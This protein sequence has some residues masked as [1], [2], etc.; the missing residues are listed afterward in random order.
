MILG[1]EAFGGELGHE[2]S[3]VMIGISVIKENPRRSKKSAVCNPKEGPQQYLA[4]L[5]PDLRPPASRTI[6]NK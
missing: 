2:G 5:V 1:D 4:M 3:P 6:Y